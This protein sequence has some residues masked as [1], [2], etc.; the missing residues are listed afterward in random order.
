MKALSRG[1]RRNRYGRYATARLENEGLTEEA[2]LKL[3]N[4]NHRTGR[5]CRDAFN[6]ITEVLIAKGWRPPEEGA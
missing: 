3:A 2:L 6:Q 4:V 1:G 5:Y